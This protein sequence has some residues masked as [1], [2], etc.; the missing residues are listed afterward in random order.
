MTLH[1]RRNVLA[2]QRTCQLVL[3]SLF[4][5]SGFGGASGFAQMGDSQPTIEWLTVS[6]DVVVRGTVS[7]LAYG[8]SEAWKR[9]VAFQPI[10]VT[11]NVSET[12][13]GDAQK[14]LQ[15]VIEDPRGTEGFPRLKVARQPVLWFL[16]Q[17]RDPK[18]LM[19]TDLPEKARWIELGSPKTGKRIPHPVLAMDFQVIDDEDKLIRAVKTELSGPHPDPIRGICID[20]PSALA[21]RAGPAADINGL[22]MPVTNRLAKLARG[23]VFSKEVWVRRAGVHA[24]GEFKSRANAGI[25]VG[26]L[27][28]PASWNESGPDNV[29]T[30]V[31]WVRED[32]W[33]VLQQWKV[34]LP[35]APIIREPIPP[36]GKTQGR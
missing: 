23:W 15:F 25:L 9:G 34:P 30:R 28:D 10:T 35:P 33:K 12:L 32:A 19:P 5:I 7:E 17:K 1:T 26:L 16:L 36:T 11:L 8:V 18:E 27:N 20:I 24:L 2:R 29:E 13:K 22:V 21:M 6:S 4:V 14:T 3:G 31:Y